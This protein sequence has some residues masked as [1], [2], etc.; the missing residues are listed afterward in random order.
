MMGVS[1]LLGSLWWAFVA[2]ALGVSVS[3]ADSTR[4]ALLLSVLTAVA[5][6]TAVGFLWAALAL[7]P[8][9]K[10]REQ[11]TRL[12]NAVRGPDADRET[13]ATRRR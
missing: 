5:L 6:A 2:S 13:G 3:T 10:G 8:V 7:R 9:E 12:S 4:H 11:Q 1:L